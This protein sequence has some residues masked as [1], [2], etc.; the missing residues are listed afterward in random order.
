MVDGHLSA[1]RNLPPCSVV[2]GGVG[3]GILYLCFTVDLP[4]VTH[5]HTVDFKDPVVHCKD[6]GDMVTFVDNATHSYADKDGEKVTEVISSKYK[7]TSAIAKSKLKVFFN[8]FCVF[9]FICIF[10]F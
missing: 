1:P 3:S 6:D 2:Q 7:L 8:V 9:A 5:E 10:A 4:D